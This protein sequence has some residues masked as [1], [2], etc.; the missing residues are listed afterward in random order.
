VKRRKTRMA[1]ARHR[2]R[3]EREGIVYWVIDDVI[4]PEALDRWFQHR[5][6][7]L[8]PEKQGILMGVDI[9]SRL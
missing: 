6:A 4:T 9:A 1:E 8:H 5:D 3:R 2:A 7:I